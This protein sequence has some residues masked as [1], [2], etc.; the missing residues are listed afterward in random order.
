M[1]GKNRIVIK[2]STNKQKYVIVKSANNKTLAQTETYKTNQGVDNAVKA[3]K[4]VI[5]NAKVVDQTKKKA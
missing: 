1:A 2:D 5:K 4:K 3:L